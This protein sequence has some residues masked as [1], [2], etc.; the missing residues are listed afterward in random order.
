MKST[1]GIYKATALLSGHWDQRS[2]PFNTLDAAGM[3]LTIACFP[4]R[5]PG[6]AKVGEHLHIASARMLEATDREFQRGRQAS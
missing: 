5:L 3:T 2:L 4:P 1:S 6:T